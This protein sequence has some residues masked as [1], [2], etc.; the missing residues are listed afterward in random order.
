MNPMFCRRNA[1]ARLP[2]SCCNSLPSTSTEPVVASSKPVM[3]ES[4]VVLPLPLC[5]TSIL[6]S[7][8]GTSQSTPRSARTAV[9]PLPKT[10]STLRTRTACCAFRCAFIALSPKHDR[11]L[12]C[13]HA[14][15][16][17][18]ARQRDHDEDH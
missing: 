13:H 12:E 3:T 7:P 5:P 1:L 11:R 16:A 6:I 4:R 15:D 2:A 17:E 9:S 10:F 8:S 14:P 18:Q